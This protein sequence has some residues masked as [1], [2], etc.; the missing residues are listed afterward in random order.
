MEPGEDDRFS[1]LTYHSVTRSRNL[2]FLTL[3]LRGKEGTL[4]QLLCLPIFAFRLSSQQPQSNYRHS[5]A[6]FSHRLLLAIY[7]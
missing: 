6:T 4:H 1:D 2:R 7:E 5:I 3:Q